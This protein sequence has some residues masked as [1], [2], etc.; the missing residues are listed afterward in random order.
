MARQSFARAPNAR[1]GQSASDMQASKRAPST[2]GIS[3][4]VWHKDDQ[5]NEPIFV[6]DAR[7]VVSLRDTKQQTLAEHL[8][9]RTRLDVATQNG[10]P[11]LQIDEA[12][13][14]EAG[15]Y[16]CTVE[17]HKAPTQTFQVRVIVVGKCCF[18]SLVDL[19]QV[20]PN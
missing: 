10:L 7:G 17:F 13:M 4:I 1:A 20:T 11:G 5:L 16:T 3:L 15:A 9:G 8:R 6:A 2:G 12:T 19:Q 14:Q 18:V